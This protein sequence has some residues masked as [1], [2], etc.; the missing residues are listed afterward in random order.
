MA[1]FERIGSLTEELQSVA[2]ELERG[3][4]RYGEV[5]NEL[6]GLGLPTQSLIAERGPG[7]PKK[8]KV[9]AITMSATGS[10][11]TRRSGTLTQQVIDF[12]ANKPG[13][14][15]LPRQIGEG[16]GLPDKRKRTLST[17]LFLL[18]RKKRI[19]KATKG[20]RSASKPS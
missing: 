5:L 13:Q 1:G 11:R 4:T 19:K 16:L 2:K 12:L 10:S 7:R 15:F 20:Y 17:T 6:Q 9:R 8:M 18:A 14:S 3:F